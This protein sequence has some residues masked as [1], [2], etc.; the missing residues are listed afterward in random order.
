METASVFMN[1][2]NQAIRLPKSVEFP[3]HVKKVH[4]VVRGEAR[5]IVPCEHVWDDWFENGL[6]VSSDFMED[7]NQPEDQ[8]RES[9]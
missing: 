9:F 1:N 2:R 3:K 5:I 4:V 6:D 8:E 7:R